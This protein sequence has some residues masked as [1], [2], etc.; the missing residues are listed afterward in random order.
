MVLG[1]EREKPI[2]HPAF[3]SVNRKIWRGLRN[4]AFDFQLAVEEGDHIEAAR[5]VEDAK[6]LKFVHFPFKIIRGGRS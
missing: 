1:A 5:L 4:L 2:H 3:Q 6:D